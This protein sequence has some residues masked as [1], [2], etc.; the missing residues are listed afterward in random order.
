MLPPHMKKA[1]DLVTS[2]EATT[3]G[4]IAQARDKVRLASVYIK[5]ARRL[6][7]DLEPLSTPQEALKP[8]A[9]RQALLAAVGISV[10]ALAHLTSDDQDK[11][12]GEVLAEIQHQA[13][14]DWKE[15][16]VLRFALTRGDSLGGSSRN[17][18]GARAKDLFAQAVADSLSSQGVKP[19][20]IPSAGGQR[21]TQKLS[22]GDRIMVFDGKPR[23]VGKNIDVILL[24]DDHETPTGDLLE[25]KTA[26]VACGEIKGGIDP[27]GAD[28]HWKTANSALQRVRASFGGSPPALFFAAAAI[29]DSMSHE[30]VSQLRDNRLANAAN[31]TKPDQVAGLANWVVSL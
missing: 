7:K 9:I 13:G 6:E 25:K 14:G 22:W 23:I 28:E 27:A 26:Y 15:E 17:L 19:E 4:F 12:L 21:K 20:V 3:E 1:A 30:I 18:A 29:V 11:I 31:L 16:L 24:E 8:K 2:R 10:K 5:D